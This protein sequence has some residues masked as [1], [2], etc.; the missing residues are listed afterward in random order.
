MVCKQALFHSAVAKS[1]GF[2]LCP[3]CDRTMV[4]IA[5]YGNPA[6]K[7]PGLIFRD[8]LVLVL[9]F[10]LTCYPAG[11]ANTSPFGFGEI[12]LSWSVRKCRPVIFYSAALPKRLAGWTRSPH[13]KIANSKQISKYSLPPLLLLS[14]GKS[15]QF[16]KINLYCTNPICLCLGQR[17]LLYIL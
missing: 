12:L 11:G 7:Q 5:R 14:N 8:L 9:T 16:L 13:L 3:R 17:V 15:R 6:L 10:L 1:A 2:H 4:A